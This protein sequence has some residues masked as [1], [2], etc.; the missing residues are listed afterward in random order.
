L[1]IVIPHELMSRIHAVRDMT[2][3]RTCYL[4]TR[5]LAQQ[6]GVSGV[7]PEEGWT[8]LGVFACRIDAMEESTLPNSTIRRLFGFTLPADAPKLLQGDLV[9]IDDLD[10][11][12]DTAQDE[13]VE[14]IVR[15]Y[16]IS[17]PLKEFLEKVQ[18][19]R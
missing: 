6:T 1:E 14:L 19:E 4:Y 2:L 18:G 7:Q 9:R 12:V 5:K 16:T 17:V 10:Y 13:V 11:R 15:R 8:S 3:D